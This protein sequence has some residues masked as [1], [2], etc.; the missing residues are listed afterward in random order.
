LSVASWYRAYIAYGGESEDETHLYAMVMQIGVRKPILRKEFDA[1]ATP[2]TADPVCAPPAWRR[3]P[4]RIDF[5]LTNKWSEPD[6]HHPRPRIR[7]HDGK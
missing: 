6:L 1:R 2:A 3:K 7:D 4:I 5:N